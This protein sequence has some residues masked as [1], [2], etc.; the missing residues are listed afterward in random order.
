MPGPTK[1]AKKLASGNVPH[2]NGATK[3]AAVKGKAR[4]DAPDKAT[5][6]NGASRD[7]TGVG[8]EGEDEGSEG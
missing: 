6:V 7:T 3:S 1:G 4:A 8:E 5:H 2:T